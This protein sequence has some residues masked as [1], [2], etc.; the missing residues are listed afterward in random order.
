MSYRMAVSIDPY[1]AALV[2]GAV[3]ALLL[4][5]VILALLAAVGP[6]LP[7][8]GLGRRPAPLGGIALLAAFAV[9]PFIAALVSDKAYEYFA[10]KR[11]DFLGF[12][13]AVALVFATGLIDDWRAVRPYQKLGGQV[14]AAV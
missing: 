6:R 10:P 9:A 1:L 14:I 11:G 12:L 2:L 7:L 4:S 8:G 13:A 5:A 3:F